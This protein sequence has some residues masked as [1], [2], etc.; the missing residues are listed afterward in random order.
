MLVSIIPSGKLAGALA[1]A[2]G[3]EALRAPR[4]NQVLIR[5]FIQ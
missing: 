4:W 5:I 1:F 3:A 2:G